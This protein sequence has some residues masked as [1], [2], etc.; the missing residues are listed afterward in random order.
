MNLVIL[1][2][3]LNS[4]LL[5]S[6]LFCSEEIDIVALIPGGEETLINCMASG[7]LGSLS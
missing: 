3:L 2:A 4:V 5:S 1:V 6:A 7:V